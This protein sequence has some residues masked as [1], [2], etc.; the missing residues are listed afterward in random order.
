[1]S[2]CLL[3]DT[4]RNIQKE[5]KSSSLSGNCFDF[6]DLSDFSNT[7]SPVELSRETASHKSHGE[8]YSSSLL[9]QRGDLGP[10]LQRLEA[11]SPR[12]PAS[13]HSLTVSFVT[14]PEWLRSLGE[15]GGGQQAVTGL[16]AATPGMADRWVQHPQASLGRALTCIYHWQESTSGLSLIPTSSPTWPAGHHT[17]I[18]DSRYQQRILC[19]EFLT[20]AAMIFK[21]SNLLCSTCKRR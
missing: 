17:Q 1:M 5:T 15:G 16:W 9:C 4:A 6:S 8:Q 21:S 10:Q 20:F 13:S 7:I 3:D 12:P 18:V 11:T 19:N 2:Q 14:C